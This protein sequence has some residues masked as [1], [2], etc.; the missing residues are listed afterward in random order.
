MR[1][2]DNTGTCIRNVYLVQCASKD[3]GRAMKNASRSFYPKCLQACAPLGSTMVLPIILQTKS[4]DVEFY[5]LFQ[6]ERKSEPDCVWHS[7][8]MDSLSY[9]SV[10]THAMH[11]SFYYNTNP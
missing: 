7:G 11:K 10:D 8:S 2:G 5:Q 3:S 9:S 4:D 1:K 6:E